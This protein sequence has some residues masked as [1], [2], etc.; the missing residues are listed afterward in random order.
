MHPWELARNINSPVP[1][2]TSGIRTFGDITCAGDSRA[3]KPRQGLE[4]RSLVVARQGEQ[5]STQIWA[6]SVQ[7][8]NAS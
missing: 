5:P 3:L 6:V 7:P 2:W 1:P 8:V 4:D